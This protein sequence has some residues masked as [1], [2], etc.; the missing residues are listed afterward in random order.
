VRNNPPANGSEPAFVAW[1]VSKENV[2]TLVK[3]AIDHDLCVSVAGSGKDVMNR[4]VSI[5]C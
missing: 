1:P 3:F 5:G 4:D 2:V